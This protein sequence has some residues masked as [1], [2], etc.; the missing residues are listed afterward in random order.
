MICKEEEG[1]WQGVLN[2]EVMYFNKPGGLVV[3]LGVEFVSG[4]LMKNVFW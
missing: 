2:T 1:R 3:R 4:N